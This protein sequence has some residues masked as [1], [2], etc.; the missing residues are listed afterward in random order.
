LSIHWQPL[1]W[2][3]RSNIKRDLAVAFSKWRG[4]RRPSPVRDFS[5]EL[6]RHKFVRWREFVY[7][8]KGLHILAC[9]I[10]NVTF[11]ALARPVFHHWSWFARWLTLRNA[12]VLAE[13]RRR[14]L[15]RRFDKWVQWT[16][17]RIWLRRL[18]RRLLAASRTG[19]LLFAWQRWV[20]HTRILRAVEIIQ[21][22]MRL[23]K[24]WI[25]WRDAL[26]LS[27]AL[28]GMSHQAALRRAWQR[29]RAFVARC[30]RQRHFRQLWAKLHRRANLTW[31]WRHWLEMPPMFRPQFPVRPEDLS[32]PAASSPA[33]VASTLPPLEGPSPDRMRP[34]LCACLRG[35]APH[36]KRYSGVPR[37]LLRVGGHSCDPGG[38]H[39]RKYLM[40]G[41]LLDSP[42]AIPRDSSG[43]MRPCLVHGV[44]G[45]H[46]HYAQ[47][48]AANR[49]AE[50]TLAAYQDMS[51]ADIDARSSGT[52]A[53]RL[54]RQAEAATARRK[55]G[56]ASRQLTSKALGHV[57]ASF[58]LTW[59]GIGHSGALSQAADLKAHASKRRLVGGHCSATE[60][61]LRRLDAAQEVFA[62]VNR[63]RGG[64]FRPHPASASETVSVPYQQSGPPGKLGWD[65]SAAVWPHNKQ[66]EV[67]VG[68]WGAASSSFL[69]PQMGRSSP[70]D[71]VRGLPLCDSVG[72]KQGG[73]EAG[74][75]AGRRYRQKPAPTSTGFSL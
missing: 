29:W 32:V 46:S 44:S 53:A 26:I 6:M 18:L 57:S 2:A 7:K 72:R 48:K 41:M 11:R 45:N 60:H 75:E 64:V 61:M 71:A 9:A 73:M 63:G 36:T 47:R 27:R 59:G 68:N 13:W 15:R 51:R 31:A 24:A 39:Y 40:R 69:P 58:P 17:R 14:E 52:R 55:S 67:E 38:Q 65:E 12:A 66:V 30:R 16:K 8:R 62:S 22:H 49:Q 42:R 10:R 34:A 74:R 3:L 50:A 25:L 56:I 4:W 19:M 54:R 20:R 21:R 23:R 43:K 1:A 33:S 70:D 5:R 28:A 35:F 37:A